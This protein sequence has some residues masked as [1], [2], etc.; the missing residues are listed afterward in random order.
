[1]QDSL[2]AYDIFLS[3]QWQDYPVVE[4][5]AR[6][7]RDKGLSVF[8]DRWYLAP[9]QSWLDKLE[10]TIVNCRSAAIFLGSHGFGRWQQR[11]RNLALNRQARDSRFAVIPV[12]LP[13]A[14]P[15]LDFLSL[16]TWID[17]RDK[18]ADQVQ[19]EMLA[20]AARGEPA[21]P[22]LVDAVRR[23][24]AGICPYRGLDPFPRG[25]FLF[26]PRPR[27]IH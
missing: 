18:V 5:I 17:L 6:T 15:A 19:L 26:F 3:Y 1:M 14:Q 11:E 7:L 23:T 20:K 10:R 9:G 16:N 22:D 2:P 21:G 24:R 13:G 27:N 8:L 12:L 25:G 4:P